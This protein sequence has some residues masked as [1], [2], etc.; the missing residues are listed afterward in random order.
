MPMVFSIG[1]D[2]V[3]LRLV[4]TLARPGGHATGYMH[5]SHEIILKQFSLLRELAP[6]ARRIAVM[7]EAGNPSMLQGVRAVQSLPPGAGIRG[8]PDAP[9]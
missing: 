4:A 3:G 8:Q 5:G 9:A 2:P 6:A 1:G 7:F